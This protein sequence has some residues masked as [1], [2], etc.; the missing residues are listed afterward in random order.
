MDEDGVL[1]IK[2]RV[3]ADVPIGNLERNPVILDPKHPFT[4][5]LIHHVHLLHGHNGKDQ[6]TNYLKQRY[7]ILGL[8]EAVKAAF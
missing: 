7:C 6:V 8:R 5:L 3:Q 4:R 2:G 1:R